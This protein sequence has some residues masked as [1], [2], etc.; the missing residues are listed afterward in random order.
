MTAATSK[1]AVAVTKGL[2][3]EIIRDTVNEQGC[4][5]TEINPVHDACTFLASDKAFADA[6]ACS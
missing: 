5:D 2:A 4:R 1:T 3:I 6:D